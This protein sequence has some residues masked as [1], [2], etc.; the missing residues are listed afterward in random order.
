[1]PTQPFYLNKG[2]LLI[3]CWRNKYRA[4]VIQSYKAL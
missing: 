3:Y 4:A 2:I 1:L